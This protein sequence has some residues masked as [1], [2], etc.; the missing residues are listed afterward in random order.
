LSIETGHRV[1]LTANEGL[2]GKSKASEPIYC[3]TN[4]H[5]QETELATVRYAL[6][7][8]VTDRANETGVKI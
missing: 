5:E 1:L 7:L 4:K 8:T 3:R 2:S 6:W